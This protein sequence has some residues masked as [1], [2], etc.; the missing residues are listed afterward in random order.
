MSSQTTLL[1]R[2][3]HVGA[4]DET[5]LDRARQGDTQ[6]FEHLYRRSYDSIFGFCLL[7]LRSRQA[8]EDAVRHIHEVQ[9]LVFEP[10]YRM[11]TEYKLESSADAAMS[12]HAGN[13]TRVDSR[14]IEVVSDS[15]F[16]VI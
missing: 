6:A 5:L 13:V 8:A 9:P 10:P 11:R 16:G 12:T 7:R 15:M 2:I 4:S 14:T 3:R 1:G